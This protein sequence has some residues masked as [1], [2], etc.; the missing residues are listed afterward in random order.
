MNAKKL[1]LMWLLRYQVL[2][3]HQRF[4]PSTA[5]HT[6]LEL[7]VPLMMYKLT[8]AHAYFFATHEFMLVR[9]FG[10]PIYVRGFLR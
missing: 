9:E 6:G 4:E 3:V 8:Q 7:R 1:M 5:H 10:Q 2:I